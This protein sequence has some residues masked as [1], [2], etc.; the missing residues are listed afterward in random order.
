MILAGILVSSGHIDFFD[1]IGIAFVAVNIHDILYWHIGG[2]LANLN[3]KKFLF[4][5]LEKVEPWFNRI[6]RREGLYIFV[7]KFAWNLNR[8]VLLSSGYLGTKFKKFVKFSI[9]AA[10]LWTATFVSLGYLF[11]DELD[12]LKTD[13][14]RVAI[15][16]TIFFIVIIFLENVIRKI[17]RRS[18]ILYKKHLKEK[19]IRKGDD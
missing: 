10:F 6:K 7:S 17:I 18:V 2:R 16:V 4:F 8:I 11:S 19:I 1:T 12:I 13:L 14:K 9:P 15:S 3:K 5:N